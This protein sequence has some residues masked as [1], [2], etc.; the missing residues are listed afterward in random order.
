MIASRLLYFFVSLL[1]LLFPCVTTAQDDEHYKPSKPGALRLATDL[2][3]RY[4]PYQ[5]RE[6]YPERLLAK[7]NEIRKANKL[8]LL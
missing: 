7:L 8:P 3:P 1:L 5:D 2:S 4:Y 6:H